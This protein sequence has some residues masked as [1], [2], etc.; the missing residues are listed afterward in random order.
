MISFDTIFLSQY[1]QFAQ[2]IDQTFPTA[3]RNRYF[4][5]KIENY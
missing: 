5:A 3:I 1:S 2:L 4:S